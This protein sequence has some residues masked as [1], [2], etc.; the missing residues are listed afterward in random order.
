LELRQ[1]KRQSYDAPL[2]RLRSKEY[3]ANFFSLFIPFIGLATLCLMFCL[4]LKLVSLWL[5]QKT[6]RPY[7]DWRL[8]QISAG[9]EF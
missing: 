5:K 9:R 2:S 7:Q 4:Q 3:T 1:A 8:E 6:Q